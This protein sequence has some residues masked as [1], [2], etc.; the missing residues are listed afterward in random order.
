MRPIVRLFREEGRSDH[1][2]VWARVA[3]TPLS[4]IERALPLEGRIIEVG[5]GRGVV[6]ALIALGSPRRSV[7]G[8]DIDARKVDL[9]QK[10]LPRIVE[11]GGTVEFATIDKRELVDGTFDGVVFA[12]VM[13]LMDREEKRGQLAHYSASL[14]PGGVLVVKESDV[15]PWWKYRFNLLHNQVLTRLL[16]NLEGEVFDH[17]GPDFY[18]KCMVDAGLFVESFRVDRFNPYAHFM[19]VGKK[20]GHLDV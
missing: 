3:T 7:L 1:L 8:V 17:L 4:L 2:Q 14:A 12:D 6:A 20:I 15:T 9:A 10:V 11:L 5:C 18:E 19:V 16:G 13:Y